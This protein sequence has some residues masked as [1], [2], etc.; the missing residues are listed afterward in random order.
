MSKIRKRKFFI[1]CMLLF[2]ILII[3]IPFHLKDGGTVEYRAFLYKVV[4]YHVLD[5]SSET[6]YNTGLEIR[7]LGM[8]IYSNYEENKK[9]DFEEELQN[10][11]MVMVRG[12]LYYDTGKESTISG[13]CGVMDGKITSHVA[14]N[15]IPSI[16]NQS[17]FEGDYSYQFV[18]NDEIDL[19]IDKQWIVFKAM[20]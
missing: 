11:R 5:M 17:N 19:F 18:G 7:I 9:N 8:K 13:R 14:F 16:D 3:P 1:V 4:D 15:E 2:L 12:K 20:E 6:G 10:K